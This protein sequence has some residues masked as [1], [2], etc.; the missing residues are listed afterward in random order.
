MKFYVKAADGFYDIFWTHQSNRPDLAA[1]QD[2]TILVDPGP[3][4]SAS[5]AREDPPKRPPEPDED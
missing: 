4:P 2:F 3:P 1:A 5:I